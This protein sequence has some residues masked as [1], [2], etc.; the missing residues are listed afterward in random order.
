L[1]GSRPAADCNRAASRS[2]LDLH[3]DL[4]RDSS[5]QCSS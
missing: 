1:R 3:N 2:I 5:E 4:G